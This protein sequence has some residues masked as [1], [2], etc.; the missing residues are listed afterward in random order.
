LI[1]PARGHSNV[2][3]VARFHDVVKGLH[4]LGKFS[5]GSISESYDTYS[6]LDWSVVVKAMALEEVDV[7]KLEPRKACFDRVE[8]MLMYDSEIGPR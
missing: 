5:R 3:N 1:G 6:L 8:D 7:F 2:A 4:L